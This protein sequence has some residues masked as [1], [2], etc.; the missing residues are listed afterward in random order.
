MVNLLYYLHSMTRWLVAFQLGFGLLWMLRGLLAGRAYD[1][2]TARTMSVIAGTFGLQWILGLL[3]YVAYGNALGNYS[4]G[5]QISHASSMTLALITAHLYLPF[6]NRPARTRYITS[7]AVIVAVVVLV[8]TGV[9]VLP[10]GW[11]LSFR[12]PVAVAG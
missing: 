2:Q 6:R 8:V 5:Y 4:I 10:H 3:F 7:I 1:D 9:V 11:P 12:P